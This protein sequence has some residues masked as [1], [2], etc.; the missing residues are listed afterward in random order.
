M[1]I[2]LRSDTVTRPSESMREAMFAAPVGDD[3]FG[4]DPSVKELEE[5]ASQLFEMEA[6]LFCPSG[7]MT[8]Q[9]AIKVH[10]QPGDEVICDHTAHIYI[11]EGGG[12]AFH[13]GCSVR[14]LPGNRGQFTAQDVIDNINSIDVHHPVTRLV[15]IENTCNKGGGSIW[16]FDEIIRIR[17]VCTENDLKMHLDGARIFNA[18]AAT[19]DDPA[20]F[21]RAFDSISVCL[22]KGLGAPVGSLLMGDSDFIRQA[23]RFRRMMGGGMRQAGYLAAAGSYALKNNINRLKDDHNRATTLGAVVQELPFIEEVLPVETNIVLFRLNEAMPAEMFIKMLAEKELLV[24]PFGK[25]YIRMVTHLD[26][27]DD[28]LEEACSLLRKTKGR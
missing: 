25:Q 10:T 18:L 8:N 26:F 21:G 1:K 14:L 24:V 13:S 22:S 23:R 7:T 20:Q 15:S 4:E 9:L 19:G 28:H 11:H 12:I 2:D 3:V 16:D 6:A 5:Y 27:N 17:R